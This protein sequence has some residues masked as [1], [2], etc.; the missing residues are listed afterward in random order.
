M[1]SFEFL[2][3]FFKHLQ[4]CMYSFTCFNND[5]IFKII[6]SKCHPKQKSFALLK[7][8]IKLIVTHIHSVHL[9]L[10]SLKT[11]YIILCRPSY[12]NFLWP[13]PEDFYFS[14]SKSTTSWFKPKPWT[15][16]RVDG[17]VR[18]NGNWVL[19]IGWDIEPFLIG[20]SVSLFSISTQDC[21]LLQWLSA[22]TFK[23]VCGSEDFFERFLEQCK[24]EH[25]SP[26]DH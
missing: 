19:L 10:L 14:K 6:L 5:C 3:S 25:L 23:S 16:P 2:T 1:V 8:N 18:A 12:H 24:Y 9:H 4:S 7:I 21:W 11:L 13:D 15:L 20:I 26:L 22:I 17:H